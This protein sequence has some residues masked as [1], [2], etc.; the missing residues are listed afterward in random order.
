MRSLR[1]LA[2]L[3]LLLPV[4]CSQ[5]KSSANNSKATSQT[6]TAGRHF[7][8]GQPA[9]S[10]TLLLEGMVS[11]GENEFAV[12]LSPGNTELF[13]SRT[14]RTRSQISVIMVTRFV[15]G[16]WTEPVIAPFSDGGFDIDPAFTPDGDTLFF[17]RRVESEDPRGDLK[18]F[19]VTRQESG[20]SDA[21]MVEGP[22][23]DGNVNV[24]QTFSSDGYMYF[25]STREG[26]YGALDIY[27]SRLVDGEFQT[28]ENL[29]PVVNSENNDA[30]P[31][32][33]PDGSFLVF[34]TNRQLVISHQ[35]ETGWTEPRPLELPG[36]THYAPAISRDGKWF[37][38]SRHQDAERLETTLDSE[39]FE[40]MISGARNGLSDIYYL[41][42]DTVDVSRSGGQ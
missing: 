25:G 37:F 32:I 22:V 9:N 11:T 19:Y 6:D 14:D 8:D 35:T 18:I 12:A 40:Q 33:A 4:G 10:P 17:N 29:G 36:N 30:N 13:F 41:S 16:E 15:E 1:I 2:A 42:T 39:E 26:G 3:A 21:R 24:F 20:W 28:P 31:V 34:L 27:R 23:N 38:I 7:F 5:E